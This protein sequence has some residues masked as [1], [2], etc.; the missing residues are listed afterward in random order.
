MNAKRLLSLG[1][2]SFLL[3][4]SVSFA[5][6]N[7]DAVSKATEETTAPAKTTTTTTPAKATTTAPAK[8]T[9]TPAKAATTPAK[10]TTTT[11]AK[12]TAT[13]T[14]ATTATPAKAATTT[15]A[16]AATPAKPA[17]PA[18]PVAAVKTYSDGVY[19][20]IFIDG[21][22]MQVNVD[23]ELKDNKVV[24]A[25]YRYLFYKG[26]DY[27]KEAVDAKIMEMNKQYGEL[28]TYLVGK[29]IRT[30][31]KDLY[32]PGNIVKNTN[33]DG[34]TGATL[35]SGKIVS[36]INDALNRG[37]YSLPK[38][39]TTSATGEKVTTVSTT[40]PAASTAKYENGTYRG[41]FLDSGEAQVGVQIE[42][43][44]NKVTSAKYR[45][46]FYK[47]I[48]YKNETADSKIMTLTKQ[49]TDLLT[50][51]VGKDVNSAINSLYKP[52]DIVKDTGIDG[53]TG[54]TL[55]S[56]KVISALRDALNRGVY[57]YPK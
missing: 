36:A 38:V 11:A 29:D 39:T 41:V 40:L 7:V 26:I 35:R 32:V 8:T 14:K 46:L 25:K 16:K 22:E 15:P 57:S 56:G 37:V 31:V 24:T 3:A 5:G 47:A 34:V 42:I 20:G 1:L 23:F 12:T 6:V 4:T 50:S 10:A 43:V 53:M 33:I 51:M 18:V 9:T 17:T 19:R 49:Y 48:D 52:G 27:R 55:K 28:L 2:C 45:H 44:D 13:T 30:A 54:A 21:A